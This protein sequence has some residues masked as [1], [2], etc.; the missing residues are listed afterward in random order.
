M[1][2]PDGGTGKDRSGAIPGGPGPGSPQPTPG[3][4]PSQPALGVPQ[5]GDADL[6]AVVRSVDQGQVNEVPLTTL[7]GE[8]SA[9]ANW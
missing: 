2:I 4:S 6:A 3:T 1:D 5:P 9:S 8:R 7:V